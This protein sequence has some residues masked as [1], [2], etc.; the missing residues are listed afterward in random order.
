MILFGVFIDSERR[1]HSR[2][3]FRGRLGVLP[4]FELSFLRT[5]EIQPNATLH[6]SATT[7]IGRVALQFEKLDVFG[8]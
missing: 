5:N 6:S 8:R 2:V 3:I 4:R 1:A 7:R